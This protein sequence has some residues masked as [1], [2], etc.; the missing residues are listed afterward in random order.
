MSASSLQDK[1]VAGAA[2]HQLPIISCK[3]SASFCLLRLHHGLLPFIG[4]QERKQ[5]REEEE[6]EEEEEGKVDLWP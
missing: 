4:R 6:V 2:N 3:A 5:R 1:S